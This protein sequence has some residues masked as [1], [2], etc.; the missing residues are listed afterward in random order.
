[1]FGD[2]GR[3]ERTVPTERGLPA[4]LVLIVYF[5]H[6]CQQLVFLA[7]KLGSIPADGSLLVPIGVLLLDVARPDLVLLLLLLRSPWLLLFLLQA[8]GVKLP[9]P[10]RS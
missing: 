8:C 4:D 2:V 3:A 7:A 9:H 10:Y 1:M 5:A 6:L